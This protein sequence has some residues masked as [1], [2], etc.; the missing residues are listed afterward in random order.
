MAEFGESAD[1]PQRGRHNLTGAGVRHAVKELRGQELGP[2]EIN[3]AV[4]ILEQNGYVSVHKALGT[5]LFRFRGV[6]LTSHGRLEYENSMER[7]RS[8]ERS[9]G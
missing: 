1:D 7:G 4:E 6:E 5:A 8:P 2:A 9:A 3:D